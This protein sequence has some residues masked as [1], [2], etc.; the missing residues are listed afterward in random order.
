MKLSELC[1]SRVCNRHRCRRTIYA[2]TLS[3]IFANIRKNHLC[4]LASDAKIS[5]SLYYREERE[6]F[7][8]LAELV[9]SKIAKWCF[10][11]FKECKMWKSIGW[12]FISFEKFFTRAF[13]YTV[14]KFQNNFLKRMMR[15]FD[16]KTTI[17]ETRR[18]GYQICHQS[19]D[20]F[21]S[22]GQI[23]NA[24]TWRNMSYF[25]RSENKKN[26]RSIYD[27]ISIDARRIHIAQHRP[28]ICVQYT[29]Y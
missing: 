23:L 2:K 20:K 3:R 7:F 6:C 13:T 19:S 26:V 18:G 15:F 11:K 24:S 27:I 28:R 4:T 16:E 22:S 10:Q 1:T 9:M 5:W 17:E 12:W 29:R 14:E 25:Y 8:F 21:F